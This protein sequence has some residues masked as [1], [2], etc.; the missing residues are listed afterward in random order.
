MNLTFANPAGMWALLGI[1]AIVLIHFLQTKS[2]RVYA[3]TLF[4][5]DPLAKEST[6][7]SKIERLRNSVPLWLQLL[8]VLLLAWLL[9]APRWIKADS[10]QS[11]VVVLD[12]SMAMRAFQDNLNKMLPERLR[13]L[14][15][16]AAK[17]DWVVMETD[18]TRPAI[19][20]GGNVEAL[21]E[22]LGKWKPNLGSHDPG[23]ALRLGQSLLHQ[24]GLL[25]FV[26]YRQADLPPGAQLIAVGKPTANCGFAGFRFDADKNTWHALV[27]NYGDTPQQR[28]WWVDAGGQKIAPEQIMLQPNQA[29]AL[30][31]TFPGGVQ[32]CA[33]RLDPDA[34]TVDDS[35]PMVL[36]QPKRLKI[37]SPAGTPFSDFFGKL[38]Q[39]IP[40]VDTVVPATGTPDVELAVYDPLLPS[41]PPGA[42]IVFLKEPAPRDKYVAGEIVAERDPLTDSLAWQGLLCKETL[43]IPKREGDR[44]L[45]W[46]GER[47]LIILR[48]G[49]KPQLL[50]NFDIEQSNAERLP[51]FVILLHRFVESIRDAKIAPETANVETNQL[52]HVTVDPGGKPVELHTE[53]GAPDIVVAPAQAET[54]RAP[55][56]PG[57]FEVRQGNLVL[58]KAAAHF[59]DTRVAD[60]HDAQTIDGL[61]GA[62]L[63][64][65][66]EKNSRKDF[67]LPV[68]IL[69]AAGT[70]VLNWAW[71]GRTS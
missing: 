10:T 38:V 34:F 17:T 26:S 36:P 42:A 15:K 45:L 29:L 59:T 62:T 69:L 9:S 41:L 68:W 65:I 20:S 70:F 14:S 30:K 23:P 11:V 58:L 49:V 63:A 51:A 64:A 5:L 16:A 4:L 67:L 57:F 66:T 7:G 25:V 52:L 6:G 2:R 53:D 46:Q 21:A 32:A 24:H 31:G 28:Q 22:A 71:P 3:S 12:S 61:K 18:L 37:F 27:K 50:F 60:L 44:A 33:L 43:N 8:A 48:G 35:L 47:P 19:Y 55:V 39:S 40:A 56:E 1:P 13:E 54:L